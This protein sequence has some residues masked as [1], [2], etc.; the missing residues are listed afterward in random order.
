MHD[1]HLMTLPREEYDDMQ[2]RIK[3]LEKMCYQMMDA[4]D[5]RLGAVI[6]VRDERERYFQ[7]MHRGRGTSTSIRADGRQLH[8]R[9]TFLTGTV[10]FEKFFEEKVA[11]WYDRKI[12]HAKITELEAMLSSIKT[13]LETA[14]LGNRKTSIDCVVRL[15]ESEGI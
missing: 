13:K 6:M 7:Q 11:R 9:V 1:K 12:K 4:F 3:D 2:S 10:E 8:E 5:E 15:L 14:S